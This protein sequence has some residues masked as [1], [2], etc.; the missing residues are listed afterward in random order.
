MAAVVYLPWRLSKLTENCPLP[1]RPPGP[2][3]DFRAFKA[4][5][6]EEGWWDRTLSR[7]VM[8]L[9]P[10]VAMCVLGTYLASSHPLAA[11]LLLSVGMQQAG[12][13]GHDMTHSR[14]SAYNDALLRYARVTVAGEGL[15]RVEAER[16]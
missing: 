1:P 10:I 9:L 6:Q 5:L 14:D 8:L 16:R 13:L 7:D 4:Q 15:R 2:P 3:A 12:W 11:I